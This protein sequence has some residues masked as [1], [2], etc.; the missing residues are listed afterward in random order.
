M[1]I[2]ENMIVRN[3]DKESDKN[4]L[5]EINGKSK[6][7]MI[8]QIEE[9]LLTSRKVE[10][11]EFDNAYLIDIANKTVAYIF[12]SGK[13]KQVIY[14]ECLVLKDYRNKGVGKYILENMSE[15]I[16]DTNVWEC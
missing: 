11:L 7:N 10:S 3:F 5:D 14:F 15:Y 13:S 6:S 4:I 8:H 9:R 1:E 16:F 12:L 2:F